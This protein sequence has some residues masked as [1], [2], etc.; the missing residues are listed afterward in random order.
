MKKNRKPKKREREMQKPYIED[1]AKGALQPLHD[2]GFIECSADNNHKWPF[3]VLCRD[4]SSHLFYDQ[5]SLEAWVTAMVALIDFIFDCQQKGLATNGLEVGSW[6]N[7]FRS[8]NG[9]AGGHGEGNL[10]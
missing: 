6:D 7:R 9:F 1:E 2:L 4:R 8:R 3:Q 5:R 10:H